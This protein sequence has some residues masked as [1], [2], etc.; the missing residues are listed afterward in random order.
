MLGKRRMS[1]CVV[2][3]GVR[4]ARSLWIKLDCLNLNLNLVKV[5]AHRKNA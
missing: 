1:E 5:R 3:Q 4:M 2:G